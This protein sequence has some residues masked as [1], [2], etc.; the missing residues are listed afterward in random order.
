MAKFVHY[1]CPDCGGVFRHLHTLSDEPPPDRC[2]LCHAWMNEDE[3]PEAVFVPQAP[4]IRKSAYAR[5][6]DAT[7]RATEAASI[8]RA[9]EAAA[10]LES[11]FAKQPKDEHNT[12]LLAEF[13]R[14]QVENTRSELRVTNMRDPSEM[15]PG[16]TAAIMPSA[17]AAA[18]RLA[19]PTGGP[20]FQ[21]P[22]AGIPIAPPGQR[23]AE[24][25]SRLT[26]NH[27]QT[28]A[29]MIRAGQMGKY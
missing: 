6:V 11:E 27:S 26:Q 20:G 5:S 25:V 19:T 10:M 17:A 14:E 13:Q 3:P 24:V 28:A 29:Q 9:D 8:E 12:A 18:A 22:G 15:R 7:Y 23:N 21:V 16:D 4:G 2:S 1:K